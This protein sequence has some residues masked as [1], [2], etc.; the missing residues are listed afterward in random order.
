MNQILSIT[1]AICL[2]ASG[3]W[4]NP[5][6]DV[7][8]ALD[9]QVKAWNTGDLE[10]A[11]SFYWDSPDM[12]WISKAGIEKGYKTVL[13]G[14]RKDFA[15]KSKMGVYT[16]EP[17]N[18]EQLSKRVVHYVFRW[19]IELGGKKIMGGLSSQIWKKINGRWVITSEHAS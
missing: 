7:K 4:A 8:A 19:K 1:L 6:S 15:N 2:F 17:M 14:Y 5:V 10:K 3:T 13:E 16:Y 18:I 12:L 9:G 11:M